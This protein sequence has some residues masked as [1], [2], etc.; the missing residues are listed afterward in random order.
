MHTF[1]NAQQLACTA[2][3]FALKIACTTFL[4]FKGYFALPFDRTCPCV[5]WQSKGHP[6]SLHVMSASSITP[7]DSRC[8]MTPVLTLRP[9]EW[10]RLS[11]RVDSSTPYGHAGP[12]GCCVPSLGLIEHETAKK[13]STEPQMPQTDKVT[14]GQPLDRWTIT[15]PTVSRVDISITSHIR[16]PENGELITCLGTMLE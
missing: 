7:G 5:Q 14:K 8:W 16:R 1:K 15:M 11:Y 9:E 12:V 6:W 3:W 4:V 2:I 13:R 10:A